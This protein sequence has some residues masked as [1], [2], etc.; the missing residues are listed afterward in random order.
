V[1]SRRGYTGVQKSNEVVNVVFVGGYRASTRE[2]KGEKVLRSKKIEK[3][4]T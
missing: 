4:R 1:E 2:Q 3:A